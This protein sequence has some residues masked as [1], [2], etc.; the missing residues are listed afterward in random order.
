MAGQPTLL[1][2][3]VSRVGQDSLVSIA[4]RYG[5]DAPGIE[6]RCEQISA[7]VQTDPVAHPVSCT[8][9]TGR[10]AVGALRSPPTP[11]SAEVKTREE[12]YL[13][14]PLWAFM[15]C[16]RVNFTFTFTLPPCYPTSTR[17]FR[18]SKHGVYF[19]TY[20]YLWTKSSSRS[21]YTFSLCLN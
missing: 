4:T 10:K 14:A 11:S 9:G 20:T 16:S 2:G 1:G 13:Y 15:A 19:R 12:L 5:L 21:V 18:L 6:S 3:T 17:E 7:F 8:I